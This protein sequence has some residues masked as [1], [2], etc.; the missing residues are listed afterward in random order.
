MVLHDEVEALELPEGVRVALHHLE[1]VAVDSSRQAGSVGMWP[2]SPPR[3]APG[4]PHHPSATAWQTQAPART[5]LPGL[6][7]LL[8]ALSSRGETSR[9]EPQLWSDSPYPSPSWGQRGDCPCSL[10]AWT[11]LGQGDQNQAPPPRVDRG[12]GQ[13]GH[14]NM[15]MSRFMSSTLVTS[16]KVTSRR[17]TT[18]LA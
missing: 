6:H 7:H 14:L 4:V 17:M 2:C 5:P 8:G 1:R 9:G 15:A 18:Q 11:G 16:R 12:R 3:P 13:G 10:E